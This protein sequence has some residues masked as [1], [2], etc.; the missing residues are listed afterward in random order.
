M[1]M[2][3]KKR[4]AELTSTAAFHHPNAAVCELDEMEHTKRKK[5]Q[6]GHEGEE[7][8][9]WLRMCELFSMTD[10]FSVS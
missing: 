9:E 4:T 8:E 5:T 6:A 10:M 3:D 7:H 1:I 2:S